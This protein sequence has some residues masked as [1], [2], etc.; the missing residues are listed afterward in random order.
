MTLFVDCLTW[1]APDDTITEDGNAGRDRYMRCLDH[2]VTK[3]DDNFGDAPASWIGILEWLRLQIATNRDVDEPIDRSRVT[4]RGATTALTVH[5]AK[6]L[7]FDRVIIPFTATPF[8][9]ST[10]R[11]RRTSASVL[12]EINA[13]P[14][15]LWEWNSTNRKAAS[16]DPGVFANYQGD[17]EAEALEVGEVIKEE[18]RLLYVATTRSRHELVVLRRESVSRPPTPNTWA[19]LLAMGGGD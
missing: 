5:K 15:L 16:A 2:L 17:G 11:P 7:Q 4:G 6:G 1:F 3:M 8:R 10:V 18:T 9:A 19:D 12:R 13:N 14:R